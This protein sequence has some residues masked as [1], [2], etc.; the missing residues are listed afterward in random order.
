MTSRLLLMLG[1]M[2]LGMVTLT[3]APPPETVAGELPTAT[4]AMASAR[5]ALLA[6]TPT[7]PRSI[8]GRP[9]EEVLEAVA[10][11]TVAPP[12]AGLAATLDSDNESP[13]SRLRLYGLA[14]APTR[15]ASTSTPAPTATLEATSTITPTATPTPT[16]T[17]TPTITPTP[18][19]T[20]LLLAIPY[21]TQA[22]SSEFA[23]SNC[24]PASLAMVL[25]S[26]GARVTVDELRDRVNSFQDTWW[27]PE[28][29][30][31]IHVIAAIARQYGVRPLDL[32][33]NQGLKRWSLDDLRAHLRAGH[34]VIPQVWYAGLPGR[35]KVSFRGDHYI[36]ITGFQNDLFFYHDPVNDGPPNRTMTSEQ[37][38]HT[39][40]N[41]AAPMTALAFAPPDKGLLTPPRVWHPPT[42]TPTPT[43]TPTPT[44]TRTPTR[45][46]TVTPTVEADETGAPTPTATVT[47]P[48]PSRGRA[49]ATPR[50]AAPP[51]TATAAPAPT[52]VAPLAPTAAPAPATVA[53]P[54]PT[55]A[56]ATVAAPTA[57]SKPPKP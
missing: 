3:Q 8:V 15:S 18:T 2:I 39:W 1:L 34:P 53:P 38:M 54:A 29:G 6:L 12:P 49:T 24:G 43:V 20:P 4:T 32:A 46:P 13:A 28:S 25:T 7:S 35:E 17:T 19:M 48:A 33:T 22:G 16:M 14:V 11:P 44:M 23:R 56:P 42:R 52:S 26:Y 9:A 21:R 36:V 50:P 37:L 27:D 40:S 41:S 57:V 31:A 5:P 55:T 47:P 45:T 10:E 51:S 30:T